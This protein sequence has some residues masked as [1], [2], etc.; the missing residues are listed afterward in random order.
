MVQEQGEVVP[1]EDRHKEVVPADRTAVGL[2]NVEQVEGQGVGEPAQGNPEHR[3]AS[4][5]DQAQQRPAGQ[6]LRTEPAKID[7]AAWGKL[8]P[9]S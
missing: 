5:R 7:W 4:A 8:D 3:T 9:K 1:D 6:W 2:P